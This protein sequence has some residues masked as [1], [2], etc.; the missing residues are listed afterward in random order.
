MMRLIFSPR[1]NLLDAWLI[2]MASYAISDGRWVGAA[3]ICFVGGAI[4]AF[5]ERLVR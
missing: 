2:T 3:V 4:S 1:L 5:A